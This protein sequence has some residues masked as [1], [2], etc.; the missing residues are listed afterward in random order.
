MFFTCSPLITLLPTVNDL[1]SYLSIV[2][3]E[4]FSGTTFSL[5]FCKRRS[6]SGYWF[7]TIWGFRLFDKPVWPLYGCW[8]WWI[9]CCSI[10]YSSSSG[11]NVLFSSRVFSSVYFFFMYFVLEHGSSHSYLAW[12]AFCFSIKSFMM[13]FLFF[14]VRIL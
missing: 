7:I 5:S 4:L 3:Y 14:Q 1:L 10:R 6:S 2:L 9:S 11:E 13:M 8:L 12:N